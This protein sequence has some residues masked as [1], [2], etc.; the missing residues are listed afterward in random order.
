MGA[1]RK[2]IQSFTNK[3]GFKKGE[4]ADGNLLVNGKAI[5]FRGVNRH[6]WDPVGGDQISEELMIKDIQN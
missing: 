1:D 3:G 2:I 6:E 5:M 4:I